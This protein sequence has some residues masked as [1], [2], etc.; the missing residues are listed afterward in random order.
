MS[1]SL[2]A[3]RMAKQKHLPSRIQF[4]SSLFA[5]VQEQPPETILTL[6]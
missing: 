3:V 1:F 5:L 2:Q 4:S 6:S